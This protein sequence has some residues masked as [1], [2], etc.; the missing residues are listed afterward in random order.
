MISSTFEI[1]YKNDIVNIR[2]KLQ[3]WYRQHLKYIT[4]MILST[5]EINYKNERHH[6]NRQHSKYIT[7]MIHYKNDLVNIW[8]KLQ[9]WSHQHSKHYK[10]YPSSFEINC[11][12]YLVNIRN[13]LQKWTSSFEIH[14]KNDII[15]IWNKL[16]KLSCQHSK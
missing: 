16:Q 7:K 15:D 1:N 3:K 12:N 2:N 6:L 5:F 10:N 9:K 11:K 14:Y 4:K 13:K 8:N